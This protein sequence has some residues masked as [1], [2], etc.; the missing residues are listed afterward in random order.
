MKK[1]KMKAAGILFSYLL[2]FSWTLAHAQ[3]RKPDEGVSGISLQN[4]KSTTLVLGENVWENRFEKA[5]DFGFIRLECLNA[6]STQL[7]RVGFFEGGIQNEAQVFQL[8][9]LPPNYILSKKTVRTHIP[10]FLSN[11]KVRLNMPVQEL[12]KIIGTAYKVSHVKGMAVYH[13]H[14]TDLKSPVLKK[15]SAI[16][17]FIRAKFNK[18]NRLVEYTFGFDY[19]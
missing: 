6:N 5:D 14:I 15:Y 17:Y 10:N 3:I 7:L 19:P 9:Y 2:L 18:S 16:G 13:W 12:L 1:N 11:L 8:S 4:G